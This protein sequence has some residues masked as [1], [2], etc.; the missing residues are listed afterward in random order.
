MNSETLVGKWRIPF[1]YWWRQR[2]IESVEKDTDEFCWFAR[3]AEK[4]GSVCGQTTTGLRPDCT[5]V[6]RIKVRD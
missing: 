4:Y 1:S 3:W 5:V 6:W 2:W